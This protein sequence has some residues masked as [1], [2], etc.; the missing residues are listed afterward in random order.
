MRIVAALAVVR[1]SVA[2]HIEND[3]ILITVESQ[4]ARE[5]TCRDRTR[6]RVGRALLLQHDDCIIEGRGHIQSLPIGGEHHRY[7][8]SAEQSV[9]ESSNGHRTGAERRRVD[10]AHANPNVN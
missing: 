9:R 10:Q 4:R 1:I 3:E 6:L 8:Y 2:L 5:P 7:R